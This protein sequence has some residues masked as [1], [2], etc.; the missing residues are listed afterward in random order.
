M[1][2]FFVKPGMRGLFS[3]DSET[4]TIDVQD[5]MSTNI[6]WAYMVPEDGVLQDVNDGSTSNVK[7]GDIILQ[8][9]SRPYTQKNVIVIKSK[10]WKANIKAQEDYK[11]KQ[12]EENELKAPCCDCCESCNAA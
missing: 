8:F 12:S 5:Y 3:Y 4:E 7:K 6:D 10:E 9:Y 1:K 2:K 11:K